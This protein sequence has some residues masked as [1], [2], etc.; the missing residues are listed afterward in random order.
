MWSKD[1]PVE[2]PKK[3]KYRENYQRNRSSNVFET[4][5]VLFTAVVRFPRYVAYTSWIM[6]EPL[7]SAYKK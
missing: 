7:K 3:E 5:R 6:F 1:M 2:S 4:V